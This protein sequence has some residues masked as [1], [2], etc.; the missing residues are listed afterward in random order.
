MSGHRLSREELILI[1]GKKPHLLAYQPKENLD[2]L[3]QKKD[4]T[5]KAST[6]KKEKV[7]SAL[8]NKPEPEFVR[9]KSSNKCII[10]ECPGIIAMG[11]PTM[12]NK[13]KYSRK[14]YWKYCN[15]IVASVK[16]RIPKNP[17]EIIIKSFIPM[18]SSW[19]MAQKEEMLGKLSTT[20][21]DF[22]NIAKGICDALLTSDSCIGSGSSTKRYSLDDDAGI[23]IIFNYDELNLLT[24]V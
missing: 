16:F 22:D 11:K 21:P 5:F 1:L 23:I 17:I 24:D 9:Y 2:Y 20:K 13:T 19:S 4:K 14:D 18:P 15:D 10:I 8:D 7:L 3:R 12:T 6:S